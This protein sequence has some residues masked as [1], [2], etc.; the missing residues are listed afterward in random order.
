MS[1]SASFRDKSEDLC[2][3]VGADGLCSDETV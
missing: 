3:E 2:R 1:L